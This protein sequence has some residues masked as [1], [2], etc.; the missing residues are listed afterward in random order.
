M[1][2]FTELLILV[3]DQDQVVGTA[4]AAHLGQR[5][6]RGGFPGENVQIDEVQSHGTFTATTSPR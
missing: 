5:L 2:H 3:G 6:Q 1:P 4:G